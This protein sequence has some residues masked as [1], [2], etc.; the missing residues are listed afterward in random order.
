MTRTRNAA[1]TDPEDDD[2]NRAAQSAAMTAAFEAFRK[3]QRLLAN[4]MRDQP[5]MSPLGVKAVQDAVARS[6]DF[7][8]LQRLSESIRLPNLAADALAASRAWDDIA[9]GIDLGA[10]TEANRLIVKNAQAAAATLEQVERAEAMIKQVSRPLATEQISKFLAGVDWAE[11]VAPGWLPENIGDADLDAVAAICLDEG[12]PLAW[13]PRA[14]IVEGLLAAGSR[15]ERQGI[16]LARRADILDDCEAA[17]DGIAHEW[18]VQCR[19]AIAADRLD[20]S[21]PAQSHAGNII[22][23]VVLSLHGR[24]GRDVVKQKAEMPV[25]E[26]PLRVAIEHFVL[27]PLFLCFTT[28]YPDTGT[29]IPGYFARHATAHAV[30]QTDVF[31]PISALV[32][33]MLA[34]SLTVEFWEDA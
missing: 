26:L 22:D 5:A 2:A 19:Q 32:A 24:G 8:A 3:Q 29:P 20:L 14:A 25:D 31:T 4:L 11:L 33:I 1:P 12:L 10:I 18:A 21:E 27:R 30:G 16:L 9:K 34:T 13:I 15:E 23:S 28:W 7:G 17:L 6:V